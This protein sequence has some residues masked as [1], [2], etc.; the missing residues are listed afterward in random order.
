MGLIVISMQGFVQS[1]KQQVKSLVGN[2]ALCHCSGSAF[3][4]L[5]STTTS[6]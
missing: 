4:S 5:R 2:V 1:V 6:Q 3:A